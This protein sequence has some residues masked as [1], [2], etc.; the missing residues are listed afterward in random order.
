MIDQETWSWKIAV[1]GDKNTDKERKI[2]A[3]SVMTQDILGLFKAL[4]DDI[5]AT[6]LKPRGLSIKSAG[7]KSLVLN[8]PLNVETGF[9]QNPN[10]LSSKPPRWIPQVEVS[11]E[12]I[13]A[14]FAQTAEGQIFGMSKSVGYINNRDGSCSVCVFRVLP[15]IKLLDPTSNWKFPEGWEFLLVL[16][17]AQPLPAGT[18]GDPLSNF[19]PDEGTIDFG[20]GASKKTFPISFRALVKAHVPEEIVAG[21]SYSS[22]GDAIARLVGSTLY[23]GTQASGRDCLVSDLSHIFTS[24][25]VEGPF[26]FDKNTSLVG[27]EPSVYQQIEAAINSGKRHIILYGPPGTGKT[28]LAEYLAGEVSERDDGDGSYLMLT[29]SSAWSSQD[30]VGGYQPLGNG[31]IGFVPG[32]LL[33]NFDKPVIIDELNRCP[34]D[35]VLGPLFSVLSGQSSALPCRVD[36]ADPASPFHVIYPEPYKGMKPYEHAPE[37]AWRMICTLNTYDK[38]QLGQ[39]SY[40]LSRRFAWIKV[41]APVDPDGFVREMATRLGAMLIEPLASNPVGAL[42]K[43]VNSFREIGGAPIVDFIKTVIAS[44]SDVNLFMQP[45]SDIADLFL[46]A[47]RMCILPLMDGLSPRESK[48]LAESI[49]IAW[50]L[51]AKKSATLARDCAEFSA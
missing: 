13:V 1:S 7:T 47:F 6:V 20:G 36:V 43:A 2:M 16:G 39:I 30:L 3:T 14:R 34:I 5:L 4:K 48:D 9:W 15:A 25:K 11:A 28:T 19:E 29:A 42:W 40:A 38:T 12:S 24:Q 37:P 51:D 44:K 10:A 8:E 41:G 33:R 31:T 27:I 49:S 26:A 46:S 50:S 35:K 17:F 21:I 18:S 45:T 23:D 22:V 32:A